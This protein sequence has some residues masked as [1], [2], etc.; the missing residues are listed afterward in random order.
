VTAAEPLP[1]NGHVG[2]AVPGNS[3][4]CWLHNSGFE[5]ILKC[6]NMKRKKLVGLEKVKTV[7]EVEQK[8]NVL[9]TGNLTLH[10]HLHAS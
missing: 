7:H 3:C 4:L 2:R 8:L 10:H 1:N 5:Q 9:V 6:H